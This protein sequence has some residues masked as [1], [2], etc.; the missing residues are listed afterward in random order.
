MTI[1]EGSYILGIAEK[2]QAA[3]RIANAIDENHKPTL[4][5]EK[6]VPL[7]ICTRDNKKFVIAPA[8]G[9]LFTLSALSKTWNYP[10][11]D[12]EWVPSYLVDKTARTKNFVDIFKQLAKGAQD[13]II[14]TD[15]DRE[16]EVI[17]YLILKYLLGK[18]NA[19]RMKFSTLT[20]IDIENAYTNRE[21]SLDLGFLNS[22]LVRHYVDWLY[23]INY[24]RAL[25][26]SLK[27]VS[28]RFKTISI[29]SNFKQQAD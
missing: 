5:R 24:S 3:K 23:G 15:Y 7:Y 13:I 4:R 6:N 16:G 29:G 19:E 11:L 2:P 26:L 22:G 20:R 25:S 17:G 12:Y 21:K 14:M 8:I 18:N 27:R 9:H 10:V 1:V 28:G